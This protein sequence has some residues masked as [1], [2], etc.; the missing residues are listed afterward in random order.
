MSQWFEPAPEGFR[1]PWEVLLPGQDGTAEVVEQP[2]IADEELGGALEALLLMADQAMPTEMLAEAVGAPVERVS[3]SLRELA[4]FYDET[5]RGFE[6]R[7][8]GGGW[9]YWTRAEHHDLLSRWVISGQQNKLTQAALETLS[10]IAYLQPISRARVSAVRGVNVDGVVRTLLARDLITEQGADEQTGATLFATTDY[11]LERMGIAS[12]D[13][14]PPLA[15]HL[16]DA[17]ELEAELANLA[18]QPPLPADADE[19]APSS[20]NGGHATQQDEEDDE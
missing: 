4:R 1:G 9:R 10:V 12:L 17:T 6:L 15:P 16:P 8:V 13:E 20:D 3:A 11:F 5:G 2:P 19:S 7:H 18:A 14:L